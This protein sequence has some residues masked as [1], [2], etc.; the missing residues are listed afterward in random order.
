MPSSIRRLAGHVLRGLVMVWIVT[1]FTFVLVHNMP[2]DP[3]QTQYELLIEKGFSPDAAARQVQVTYG[4]I[5]HGSMWSQYIHYL[6]QL[7]HFDLGRSVSA[8]GV[9]VAKEVL[10]AAKWTFGLVLAGV[11]LSFVLGV[12]LGVVAAM[13]RSSRIGDGLSIFGS[14]LHGIP[15]YVM[16]LILVTLLTV[17][18]PLFSS[19]DVN[20]LIAPGFTYAYIASL[21][22]HAVLPAFAFALSSFGGYLL[23]MKSAVVSVLGDDFILAA[24]LRGLTPGIV[25]RY[26]SRNAILPLFTVLALSLGFM[27]GGAVFIE[28]AFNYPGMG[29]LLVNSIGQRDYPEMSGAFLLITCA[30]ILANIA[31]DLLYTVVDPRVRRT[32][33]A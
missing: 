5:P 13:K 6:G 26:I 17:K 15:Q 16:A 24:E 14:L 11:L 19:G 28:N 12:V 18:W 22:S 4:F 29:A 20:S 8:Q 3:V 23:T 32:S 25:F 31:A 7:V 30:V 21:I 1:T 2:G 33:A 9:S 27:F 10:S